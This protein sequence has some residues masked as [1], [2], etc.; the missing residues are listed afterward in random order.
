MKK[1]GFVVGAV[2]LVGSA[3]VAQAATCAPSSGT[4]GPAFTV[5][6]GASCPPGYVLIQETPGPLSLPPSTASSG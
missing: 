3:S 5:A 4:A 1:L 6:E 2:L